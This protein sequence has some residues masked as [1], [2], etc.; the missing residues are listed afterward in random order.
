VRKLE[1]D[2]NW[3]IISD[4]LKRKWPELTDEDLGYIEGQ[5]KEL[6]KKI[7]SRTGKSIEMIEMEIKKAMTTGDVC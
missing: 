7:K 2:D 5:E 6:V 1:A 4:N 3:G